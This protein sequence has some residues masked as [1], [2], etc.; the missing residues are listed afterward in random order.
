MTVVQDHPM[1]IPRND[2]VNLVDRWEDLKANA[3]LVSNR[4]FSLG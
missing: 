4:V 1:V 2:Y 3:A